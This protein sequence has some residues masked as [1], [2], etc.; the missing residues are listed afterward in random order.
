MP[1]S[2]AQNVGRRRSRPPRSPE[3][4][5]S[6]SRSATSFARSC[7]L[8]CT[9]SV[10]A[11]ARASSCTRRPSKSVPIT[12]RTIKDNHVDTRMAWLHVTKCQANVIRCTR[13]LQLQQNKVNTPQ[14]CLNFSS[15]VRSTD[16]GI[17]V[18]VENCKETD[19]EKTGG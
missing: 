4:R 12:L 2:F 18:F 10:S 3:P 16:I 1:L 15:V 19:R 9:I 5:T 11:F 8:L 6:A 7:A 17:A 13:G 14:T